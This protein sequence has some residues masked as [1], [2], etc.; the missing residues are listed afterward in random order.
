M[1]MLDILKSEKDYLFGQNNSKTSQKH[2]TIQQ[3]IMSKSKML[4]QLVGTIGSQV[5]R[6]FE[7]RL[8]LQFLSN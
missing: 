3:K 8:Y 5:T 7:W 6:T 2:V 4:F 1:C